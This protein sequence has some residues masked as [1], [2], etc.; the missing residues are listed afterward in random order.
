MKIIRGEI[1]LTRV[2][3]EEIEMIRNWRNSE[4]IRQYMVFR[5]HISAEMQREWFEKINTPENLY[6]LI[7]DKGTP[8]GLIYGADI[9]WAQRA[10][11][12]AGIFIADKEHREDT[13]AM[14][15]SILLNDFAFSIGLQS[16]YIK[17]LVSN[18]R[19]VAYNKLM[20]YKL[21]GKEAGVNIYKLD[22]RSYSKFKK[23]IQGLKISPFDLLDPMQVIYDK[24]EMRFPPAG[25]T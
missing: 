25:V 18:P 15:A 9:N 6:F 16:I 2:T 23:K 24:G 14:T 5:D 13:Y 8:I 21:I 3:I 7:M 12:N 17:V 22:E 11:G 20:G 4:D 19:A 10:V 1:A